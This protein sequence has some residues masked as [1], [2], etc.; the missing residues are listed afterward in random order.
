MEVRLQKIISEAGIA[1]RRKAEELIVEGKVKVNNKVVKELGYKAD[2]EKD[3]IRVDGREI[4]IEHKKVYIALHK[5]VGIISSRKD[6]KGR[7]TVIDLIPTNTYMYPVGR[8]DFD[9]SGL[10]LLTNDGELANALMHPSFEIPKT[11]IVTINGIISNM[12]LE[13][14]QKG[15]RLED[16]VTAPAKVKVLSRENDQTKMEVT[17]T[18]GKN[19]QIRRMFEALGHEVIR[20]K[21]IKIGEITLGEL[22]SGKFRNLSEKEVKW[23]KS[24]EKA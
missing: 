21:R 19:R 16:G 9:S 7:K 14:F 15:I 8:L 24:V 17:I 5:P 12:L 3:H 1:S 22:A 23:V 10:I 18:E 11:Y 20:L 13:K 4:K 6:E 2:P